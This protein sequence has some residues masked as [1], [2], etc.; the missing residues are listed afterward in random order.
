[1][2][3]GELYKTGQIS[4]I[5]ARYIWDQYDDGSKEPP[6]KPGEKRLVLQYGEPFPLVPSC[7][8]AAWWKMDSPM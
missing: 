8:K 2:A 7:G 3:I 1:M 5:C 4:P 6:P